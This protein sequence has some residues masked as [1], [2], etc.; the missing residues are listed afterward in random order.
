MRSDQDMNQAAGLLAS[1]HRLV[2]S[3][4][5][6][7][8]GLHGEEKPAVPDTLRTFAREVDTT[9]DELSR[10]LRDPSHHLDGLPDLR[11]AQ[12]ALAEGRSEPAM[13]ASAS[14]R[15][16]PFAAL[17]A[18]TER[19]TNSLNTMTHLLRRKDEKHPPG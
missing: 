16:Y 8:A 3:M 1:S 11:A 14:S 17:T 7:E 4:M 9:L 15:I 12:S 6:L 13:T 10:A 2:N 5:A 18:E 19:I